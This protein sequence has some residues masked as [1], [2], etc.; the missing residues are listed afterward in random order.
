ME[1]ERA[2]QCT[3][4]AYN[5]RGLL[6]VRYWMIM[7]LYINQ[8]CCESDGDYD[9]QRQTDWNKKINIHQP[10]NREYI[11]LCDMLRNEWIWCSKREREKRSGCSMIICT[12][13]LLWVIRMWYMMMK[14]WVSEYVWH[15]RKILI[16]LYVCPEPLL[17]CT[18]KKKEKNWVFWV[19][20]S[21]HLL[22]P[23]ISILS[24]FLSH[25]F[26][27]RFTALFSLMYKN[28]F[29]LFTFCIGS[30]SFV[31]INILW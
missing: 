15:K 21:L 16:I 3:C 23:S 26:H 29:S 8:S 27:L 6:Y 31:L 2:S 18:R 22:P 17:F 5:V 9:S 30:F 13:M 7:K 28:F 4:L 19:C 14:M 20:V 25:P 24:F 12:M 10:T 1:R 11:M